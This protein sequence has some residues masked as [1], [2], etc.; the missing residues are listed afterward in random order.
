[1]TAAPGIGPS[2]HSAWRNSE[3][4]LTAF[5]I[6]RRAGLIAAIAIAAIAT[7]G[8]GHTPD[9]TPAPVHGLGAADLPGTPVP[10]TD[11]V[12]KAKGRGSGITVYV[13]DSGVD[14]VGIFESLDPGYHAVGSTTRDC[15]K[16]H[17]TYVAS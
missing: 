2:R 8:S 9:R 13:V 1:M 14:D 11:A 7:A 10:R 17:G 3:R 16:N 5:S 12:P 4:V 6:R 15:I